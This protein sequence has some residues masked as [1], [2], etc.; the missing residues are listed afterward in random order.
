[1][2]HKQLTVVIQAVFLIFFIGSATSTPVYAQ[3]QA[4]NAP[5][6]VADNNSASSSLTEPPD[7]IVVTGIVRDFSKK[8]DDFEGKVSGLAKGCVEEELGPNDKPVV[9]EG[10][11]CAITKL[12]DWYS[13]EIDA[14][15]VKVHD[16]TLNRNEDGVYSFESNSFFP[17]DEELD[18]NEGNSHN[19]HFTY[20]IHGEFTYRPGQVFHFKGDDDLWVYINK[21]LVI[22][23]GGVHSA[24]S[25]KVNLDDLDLVEG[26]TYPLELFF[27][28]RHTTQSNFKMETD[29]VLEKTNPIA[30]VD[31]ETLNIQMVV[32]WNVSILFFLRVEHVVELS[33]RGFL[34][35]LQP[36]QA[37]KIPNHVITELDEEVK[38]QIKLPSSE[39]SI[40][41]ENV[42]ESG[43]IIDSNILDTITDLSLEN[44]FML[45]AEDIEKMSVEI[46]A[47][48]S[49]EQLSAIPA[50]SVVSFTSI[51]ISL[52]S[53]TTV[54]GFQREQVSY[55]RTDAMHGF[56]QEKFVALDAEAMG[57][58]TVEHLQELDEDVLDLD[59]LSEEQKNNL[60]ITQ[61]AP[62]VVAEETEETEVTETEE[63]EVTE[64][65]ETEVT[66][67]EEIEVIETEET[68]VTET[69]EI[70]VIETEEIEITETEETEVTET[71][72]TETE[73]TETEVT[74]TTET[75]IETTEQ[76]ISEG[77][78]VETAD[79]TQ[80]TDGEV[81]VVEQVEETIT[82]AWEDETI[83]VTQEDG[84][85]TVTSE[86]ADSE[87]TY[88]AGEVEQA[89]EDDEVGVTEND[90]G[91][92]EVVNED[93]TK[94]TLAPAPQDVAE[95]QE[96]A[97][98]EERESSVEVSA[99]GVVQIQGTVITESV[100]EYLRVEATFGAE[101]ITAPEGAES[102][103]HLNGATHGM[104]VYPGNIMQ[105]I[106]PAMHPTAIA[107]QA[108]TQ[109]LLDVELTFRYR[110][111]GTVIFDYFGSPLKLVPEFAQEVEAEEPTDGGDDATMDVL[112]FEIGDT[113][114]TVDE[115]GELSDEELLARVVVDGQTLNV[116][117][118]TDAGEEPADGGEE[119]ANGGEEP[120]NGGEEPADG[121]EEPADGGEEPANGGE[122]PANGGEEPA[123]G[124]EE[125][126]NGGEEPAN[127]GEEPATS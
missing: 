11:Q 5:S 34:T 75:V 22:D 86:E 13:D 93:G 27:A 113:V 70:E 95:L 35:E 1:M 101:V 53:V 80:S 96:L 69:E 82:E 83:E 89:G 111:D 47:G 17:V 6:V 9:A 29:L 21:K 38:A 124:G 41:S 116:V 104:V 54:T 20:E 114:E 76:E 117:A 19:Y 71:E 61:D 62:V 46:V 105:V 24:E 103:I 88:V 84:I 44:I 107:L 91:Y 121:G 125:P 94:T 97:S 2:K 10:N 73:V 48:F 100:T 57:G 4:V 120:A 3:E 50:T 37:A 79:L 92:T 51:H 59:K 122:E 25:D 56:S 60:P 45:T 118:N 106:R 43:N 52:M 33:E 63:I 65:E 12:E 90:L 28:E 36:E 123:D 7:T 49:K 98:S 110:A 99:D 30:E 58:L 85:V 39:D 74:E 14:S 78:Q 66:E 119:P 8:H 40:G 23:V 102:G 87:L 77:V 112:P 64:T 67:T 108:A 26:E 127:G 32:E 18:G 115:N 68:E 16:I 72:V 109:A 31:F 126:A 42:V 55:L 81:S 15:R